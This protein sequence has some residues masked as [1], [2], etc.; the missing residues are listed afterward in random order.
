ME[1]KY[2]EPLLE[3]KDGFCF[4]QNGTYNPASNNETWKRISPLVDMVKA[5][6]EFYKMLKIG[7]EEE[8]PILLDEIDVMVAQIGRMIAKIK[9]NNGM[10]IMPSVTYF[11]KKFEQITKELDNMLYKQAR[12]QEKELAKGL[13]TEFRNAMRKSIAHNYNEALELNKNGADIPIP[14]EKVELMKKI[15]AKV[16]ADEIKKASGKSDKK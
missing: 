3:E 1:E 15:D 8:V 6:S 14:E 7:S 11:Q 16:K 12:I 5:T 2:R 10:V 4:V 13:A 9:R